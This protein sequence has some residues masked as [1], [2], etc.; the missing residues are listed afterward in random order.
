MKINK[1]FILASFIV[2]SILV[3]IFTAGCLISEYD[4]YHILLNA[5][6]KSGT[7]T[8]IKNNIQS[9]QTD[10]VKQQDDFDNLIR[11]WKE[12]QYLLDKTNEGV[13][14]KERKLSNVKGKLVWKEVALF[15]DFQRLFR[16]VIVNDTLRI[17]FA[18]DETIVA[19]NGELTRTKDSTFVRWP[20]LTKEF[21]LKIQKNNFTTTSNFAEKFKIYS[22]KK[23]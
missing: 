8:T 21:I 19:T 22:K 20:L 10:P 3:V 23:R 14:V 13:Y 1:Y 4:E 17:G 16:D 6:N 2:V 9:D 15:S 11:D 12:D 18:K 5:D 7:I